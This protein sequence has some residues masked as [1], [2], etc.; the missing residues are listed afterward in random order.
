MDSFKDKS[1]GWIRPIIFNEV[2]RQF[3]FSHFQVTKL[4][5]IQVHEVLSIVY[6]Q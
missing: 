6:H 1:G 3:G 4:L 2:F 5:V